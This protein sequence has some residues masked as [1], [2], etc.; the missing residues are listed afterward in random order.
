MITT[1][2]QLKARYGSKEITME[3]LRTIQ[4]SGIVSFA[5]EGISRANKDCL[6]CVIT[7]DA[8]QTLIAGITGRTFSD[9]AALNGYIESVMPGLSAEQEAGLVTYRDAGKQVE[10]IATVGEDL[11]VTVDRDDI[12][13]ESTFQVLLRVQ[14]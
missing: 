3:E 8:M 10:I 12:G 6:Q 1:F 4:S 9:I 13:A 2:S 7:F 14:H 5:N 11:S